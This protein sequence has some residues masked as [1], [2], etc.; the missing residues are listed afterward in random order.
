M[1]LHILGSGAA[2]PTDARDNTALLVEAGGQTLLIDCPGGVAHKMSRLGKDFVTI[3]YLFFTHL[4]TDHSYGLPNLLTCMRLSKRAERL[5]I[6]GPPGTQDRVAGLLDLYSIARKV[7]FFGVDVTE[8]S[9]SQGVFLDTDCLKLSALGVDHIVPTLGIRVKDKGLGRVLAYS[10]DTGPSK[11][12][13]SLAKNAH[14]LVHESAFPDQLPH[15]GHSTAGQAGDVANRARA[16][17]LILVH[18]DR[19]CRG[20]EDLIRKQAGARF[21][22]EVIVAND[23]DSFTV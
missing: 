14:V 11:N 12:V 13:M 1:Q 5:T 6:F 17:K 16:E 20:K 9:E 22:G 8:L 23:F 4:H 18:L 2:V 15:R 10:G 7:D 21:N 19:V 3:D